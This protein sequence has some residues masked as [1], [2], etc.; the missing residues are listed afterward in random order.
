MYY[1]YSIDM[2]FRGP[3]EYGRSMIRKSATLKGACRN[4]Y[5]IVKNDDAQ[6]VFIS[7]TKSYRRKDIYRMVWYDYMEKKAMISSPNKGSRRYRV[8][9]D[10]TIVG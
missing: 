4:A 7:K 9:S 10:G 5:R 1:Y 2:E 3:E 8:L 6:T